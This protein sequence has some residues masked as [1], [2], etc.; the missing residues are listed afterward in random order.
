MG[1]VRVGRRWRFE[2]REL[3][4]HL[5]VGQHGEEGVDHADTGAENR[6]Q[7]DRVAGFEAGCCNEGGGDGL[8]LQAEVNGGLIADEG[9]E[10]AD[11]LAELIKH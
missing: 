4:E 2:F 10:L 9:A 5:G 1:E 7:P 3:R 6:Y 8:G 11:E